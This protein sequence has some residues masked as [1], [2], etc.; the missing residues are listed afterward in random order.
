MLIEMLTSSNS[1]SADD[2]WWKKETGKCIHLL[3]MSSNYKT[4]AHS[5]WISEN[6]YWTYK[7]HN[8]NQILK[9]MN[10]ILFG[11]LKYF[12]VFKLYFLD[13]LWNRDFFRHLMF[14]LR[15]SFL[16]KSFANFY[17]LCIIIYVNLYIYG[18]LKFTF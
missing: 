4:T 10:K 12:T 7:Y 16:L 15:I 13:D 18:Y 11:Y 2:V 9:L 6:K 17:N 1:Q 3:I 5:F 14:F 8:G